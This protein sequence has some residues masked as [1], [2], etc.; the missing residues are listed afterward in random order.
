MTTATGRFEVSMEP[1]GDA[2]DPGDTDDAPGD[3]GEVAGVDHHRLRKH[4]E[5]G[6]VGTGQGHVLSLATAT[7]GSAG[8]VAIELV[9]G[10]LGSRRGGFALQ[11]FGLMDR[12][13]VEWRI[14]VIPDSG[15]GG[16]HGISGA[17][18]IE[19]DDAGNHTYSL[20]YELPA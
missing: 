15:T 9:E 1:I 5:G 18:V 6:L 13:E 7:E 14:P 8:Y 16:L 3:G 20:T 2:G 19:V 17:L 12:G 4:Y 11:H 10:E